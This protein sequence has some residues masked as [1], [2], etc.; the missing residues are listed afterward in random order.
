MKSEDIN[1]I[2]D[3]NTKEDLKTLAKQHGYDDKTIK[4]I[5]GK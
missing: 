3:L 1:N 2:I 5:F 4:E